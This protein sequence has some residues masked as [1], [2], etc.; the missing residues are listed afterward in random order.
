M[1]LPF[2]QKATSSEREQARKL[3]A[4]AQAIFNHKGISRG[5]GASSIGNNVF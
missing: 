4:E 2:A 5:T 3:A 1:N